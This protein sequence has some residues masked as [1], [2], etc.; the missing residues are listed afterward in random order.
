M[1]V[2]VFV[3]FLW[4][5]RP[6]RSTLTD[7]LFPYTTLFRSLRQGRLPAAE[8]RQVFVDHGEE[9]EAEAELPAA[10]VHLLQGE[11]GAG[12]RARALAEAVRRHR[13][14]AVDAAGQHQ[15]ARRVA[16]NHL[17]GDDGSGGGA[18]VVQLHLAVAVALGALARD[19]QDGEAAAAEVQI[20]TE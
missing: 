7:T 6:P 10:A 20:V 3:F 16:E 13:D 11:R 5:R 18:G 15:A 2:G 17:G 8:D 4:I 19:S 1:F 14:D 9:L 12:R